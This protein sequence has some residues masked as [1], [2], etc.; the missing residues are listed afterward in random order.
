M[1]SRRN[2]MMILSFVSLCSL[3][4]AAE[5]DSNEMRWGAE[6]TSFHE[7]VPVVD[8]IKHE[9]Y[10]D[11]CHHRVVV[12][13][14]KTFFGK[15]YP[16][17][18]VFDDAEG[19][20]RVAVRLEYAL[21]GEEMSALRIMYGR[22]LFR[23]TPK[24]IDL[25]WMIR[26]PDGTLV[27]L[28]IE[29]SFPWSLKF[30]D[31]GRYKR[32]EDADHKC[33]L[34]QVPGVGEKVGIRPA[35]QEPPQVDIDKIQNHY[36]DALI[37][38]IKA[39]MTLSD[40]ITDVERMR[41][42][43]IAAIYISEDGIITNAYI[44]ESSGS[45][46]YD[47]DVIAAVKASSPVPAPPLQL[48]SKFSS[49]VGIRFCP[50]SCFEPEKA[51]HITREAEFLFVP[52]VRYP[53]ELAAQNIDGAV[54]VIVDVSKDGKIIGER[55]VKSSGNAKLDQLAV[56]AL[57]GARMSA[58]ERNGEKVDSSVRHVYKFELVD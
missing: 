24:G 48:R 34:S 15:Q 56:T 2:L 55:I 19:L 25:V 28:S 31:V 17:E 5:A 11:K 51:S 45:N 47:N 22:P 44:A 7:N 35:Y 13:Y 30:T 8:I 21:S 9:D 46:V 42:T 39:H 26:V 29:N 57:K 40:V 23:R 50:I 27:E 14:A 3:P 41:L 18:A 10:G 53:P 6:Y 49:G 54:T 58:A 12:A 43:A 4:A 1:I 33:V 36:V 16:A 32:A 20:T 52:K 38:A 37:A